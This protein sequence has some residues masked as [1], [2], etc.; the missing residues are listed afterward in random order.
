MK[1]LADA[2]CTQRRHAAQRAWQRM[3][4]GRRLDLLDPVA[5]RHRDRGHRPRP[6]PRRALE[7]PDGR[8]A[9]LL[10]RPARADRRGDRRRAASRT[11]PRAGGSPRCCTM[12]PNTSSAISSARSR[13]PSASTTRRSRSGCW[14]PST[15]A[16][17]C[18]RLPAEVQAAIKR[19]DRIAAYFE[20]TQLAGFGATR[21]APFSA[22]PAELRSSSHDLRTPAMAA[23]EAQRNFL[24]RFQNLADALASDAA[25]KS[26]ARRRRPEN[27]HDQPCSLSAGAPR[28]EHKMTSPALLKLG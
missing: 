15:A 6:G 24:A 27:G 21:P 23:D 25:I 16:S 20:A 26:L 5:G 12:R 13:P 7:R 22:N 14:R 17:V 18:R 8:R 4:S 2:A 9:C 3:L 1:R 11:W 19:A 10:G 28:T